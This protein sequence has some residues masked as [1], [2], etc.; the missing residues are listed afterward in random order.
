[1]KVGKEKH[2]AALPNPR[3]IR[4]ACAK[5]LYR[6]LKRLRHF[7]P[8]DLLEQGEEMYTKRVIGNLEWI[9]RNRSNRKM[10][11]DWWDEA[12]CGD[13]A[14]LWNIERTRLSQAFRDAFGG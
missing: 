12:V 14:E 7:V 11:A 8:A 1:M 10:L 4:R 6:T 5:E 3:A 2:A 13:L 9:T